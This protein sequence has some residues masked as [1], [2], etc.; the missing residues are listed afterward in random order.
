MHVV[1]QYQS[2]NKVTLIQFSFTHRHHCVRC[3]LSSSFLTGPDES[4]KPK[5][6]LSLHRP[7][8]RRVFTSTDNSQ[9]HR[10]KTSLDCQLEDSLSWIL[11]SFLLYPFQKIQP[12]PSSEHPNSLTVIDWEGVWD[13]RHTQLWAE[14]HPA[15]SSWT[16]VALRC[17]VVFVVN[18]AVLQNK[19][20]NLQLNISL[21]DL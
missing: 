18:L 12:F 14:C 16:R 3:G 20:D 17:V 7:I 2:I 15:S 21:K 8:H 11:L 5:S 1:G 19:N 10:K 4:E 9:K 6:A 13:F